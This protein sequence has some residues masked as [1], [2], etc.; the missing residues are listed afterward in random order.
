MTEAL[1]RARNLIRE[2]QGYP[3]PGIRFQDLTPLLADG[4]SFSAVIAELIPLAE[5]CQA[6]AGIEARGFIFAAALAHTLNIGFVP[7]RKKGKLPF[8]THEESYGLE[9]GS[10]VLQIHQ[11]AIEPGA[12]VLLIDDVLA[13]GGTACAATKL[14]ERAGGVVV[15]LG[16]VIEIPYLAGRQKIA[17]EFPH[18]SVHSIFRI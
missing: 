10:D 5:G 13:T 3:T 9:Y 14:I 8:K 6:I 12:K 1:F 17:Q 7:I 2:I 15:A 4:P 11:D 16:T 18:L